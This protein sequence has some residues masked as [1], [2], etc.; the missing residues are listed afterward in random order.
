M[1]AVSDVG[2]RAVEVDP[3]QGD[4]ECCK[5][6]FFKKNEQNGSPVADY[7]PEHGIV[8]L[9]QTEPDAEDT[10]ANLEVRSRCRVQILFLVFNLRL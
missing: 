6:T 8:T 3:Q 4:G 2:E 5:C 1:P 10:N 9:G 7:N